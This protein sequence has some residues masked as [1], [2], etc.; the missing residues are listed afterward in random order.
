M[1]TN[2]KQLL[3]ES[4]Y[5]GHV[6]SK[7]LPKG[8][9]NRLYT[10]ISMIGG[11]IR[12]GDVVNFAE[13]ATPE[14]IDYLYH[15]VRQF[16]SK[17]H[18]LQPYA[19]G[20]K[21]LKD[22]EQ[23]QEIINLVKFKEILGDDIIKEDVDI[24][25]D[26]YYTTDTNPYFTKH[27]NPQFK[28]RLFKYWDSLGTPEYEALK[29]FGV[30]EDADDYQS[31]FRNVGDIVYPLL[32]IEWVGGVENT[33]FAKAPWKQTKE[34]GFDNLK[35]KVE[36]IGFDYMFDESVNFGEQGYACW[37]IKVL[38]DKDGDLFTGETPASW[39]EPFI[40]SLFPESA[41]NKLS[42]FR[43]YNDDQIETIEALWEYYHEEA[44]E[45]SSQFC[46]VEVVLV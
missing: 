18:E 16:P 37:D 11:D 44:S 5:Y 28:S 45:L 7:K 9:D 20:Y 32:V 35:F 40:Q 13:L 19:G 34:M 23:Y 10:L 29:L 33:E 30:E 26:G 6:L 24:D 17:I 25:A 22:S 3:K 27:F 15:K 41:R 14:E 12:H 8:L 42:S 39:D 43:N 21:S 46:R 1:K 4:G 38:I 2:L 31:D 36:P